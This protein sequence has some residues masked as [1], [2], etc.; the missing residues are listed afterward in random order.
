[1]KEF[2]WE[3]SVFFNFVWGFSL[4]GFI[5]LNMFTEEFTQEKKE[6]SSVTLTAIESFIAHW[7]HLHCNRISMSVHLSCP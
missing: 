3:N 7:V 6:T 5:D 1:M 4:L 2:V